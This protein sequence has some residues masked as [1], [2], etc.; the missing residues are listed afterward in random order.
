MQGLCHGSRQADPPIDL[1][2][3]HHAAVRADCAAFK[4]GLD[5]PPSETP[6]TQFNHGTLRHRH[7][8]L[9]KNLLRTLISCGF[10]GCAD[11]TLVEYSG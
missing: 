5:H 4:I 2:N 7:S 9:S 6:K 11:L 3:Q 1:A 8:P 10:Q